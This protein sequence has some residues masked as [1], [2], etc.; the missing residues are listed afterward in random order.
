MKNILQQ[1][2]AAAYI[3]TCSV[4]MQYLLNNAVVCFLRTVSGKLHEFE[5]EFS[6][7]AYVKSVETIF[8]DRTFIEEVW[9][10]N[11]SKYDW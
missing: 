2:E 6:M 9:A 11:G 4:E 5:G 3:E 7:L 10:G 8:A 1:D